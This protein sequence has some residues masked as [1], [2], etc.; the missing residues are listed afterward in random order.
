MNS[1]SGGNHENIRPA[2]SAWALASRAAIGAALE[3][4]ASSIDG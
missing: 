4:Q 2:R 3:T 1:G